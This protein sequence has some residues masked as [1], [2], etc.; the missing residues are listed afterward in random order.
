VIDYNTAAIELYSKNQ[1][2]SIRTLPDFYYIDNKGYTAILYILYMNNHHFPDG[3]NSTENSLF[4]SISDWTSRGWEALSERM[5]QWLFDS[6]ATVASATHWVFEQFSPELMAVSVAQ[7]SHHWMPTTAALLPGTPIN[8]EVHSSE[9]SSLSNSERRN[10]P[11]ASD[12]AKNNFSSQSI[13]E[14]EPSDSNV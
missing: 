8:I 10:D 7:I 9:P 5:T 1:F 12:T 4:S 13:S 3:R 11:I 6:S 2:Q 14:L